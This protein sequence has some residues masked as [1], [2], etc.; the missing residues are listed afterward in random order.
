MKWFVFVA[1]TAA[2]AGGAVIT[3]EVLLEKDLVSE[4][5]MLLAILWFAAACV[6]VH[7]LWCKAHRR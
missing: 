6:A 5:T 1:L 2:V 4:V 7:D 3:A